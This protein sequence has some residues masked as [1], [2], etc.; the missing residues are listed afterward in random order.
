[1]MQSHSVYKIHGDEARYG[2]TFVWNYETA[3]DTHIISPKDDRHG[4]VFSP[5]YL[6]VLYP[7]F[8]Q[9]GR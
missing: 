7:D 3:G 6:L 9:K 4:H 8:D 2:E 5:L 1:M